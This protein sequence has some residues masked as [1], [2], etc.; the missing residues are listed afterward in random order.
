MEKQ[1][2]HHYKKEILSCHDDAYNR[3]SVDA[4]DFLEFIERTDK[5]LS[6]NKWK[7]LYATLA[8]LNQITYSNYRVYQTRTGLLYDVTSHKIITYDELDSEQTQQ[9][10]EGEL[11]DDS[12]TGQIKRCQFEISQC[13][14]KIATLEAKKATLKA[15]R[16]AAIARL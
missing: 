15:R 4:K 16:D 6:T 12:I 2:L 14:I 7:K 1:R 5:Q 9:E 3:L 13:D 10:V 8:E 11:F